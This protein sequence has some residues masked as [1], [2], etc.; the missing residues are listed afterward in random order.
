MP[1]EKKIIRVT[2]TGYVKTSPDTTR[3]TF[4][5][6]SLHDTYEKAY[7]EAA[8]GNRELRNALEKL[9]LSKDALKTSNFSIEKKTEWN[10][11]TEKYEFVGFRLRQTLSIELPLD[12]VITSKVMSALGAAWP[13]LEVKISFIK[14]DTHDVKLQILESAVKDAR[15]KA[16][17]IAA[18]LGHKLGGIVCVEYSKRQ[19][20][21]NV[22]ESMYDYCATEDS[23]AANSIDYTP[24][25]IEAGDSVETEWYLE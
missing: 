5:V 15:E 9:H 6:S 12:S 21:I 18:T 10:R 1:D 13:E 22:R 11:K 25:D 7:G 23:G 14:K 4:D 24:D 17:V 3:L 20:N 16:E 2:G 8:V 19:I